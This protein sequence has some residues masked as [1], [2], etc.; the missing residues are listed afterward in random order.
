MKELFSKILCER[1]FL[2]INFNLCRRKNNK[3]KL[4]ETDSIF[5]SSV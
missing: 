2:I 5:F 1:K 4:K 3:I